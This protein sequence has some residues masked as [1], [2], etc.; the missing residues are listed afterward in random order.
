[1]AK[2]YSHFNKILL[3]RKLGTRGRTK[4]LENKFI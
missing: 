3:S 1:M 4:K 2:E